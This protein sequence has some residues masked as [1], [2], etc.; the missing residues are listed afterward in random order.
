M[1]GVE[2]ANKKLEPVISEESM[3]LSERSDRPHL[4]RKSNSIIRTP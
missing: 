4:P 3:A 1:P 2:L